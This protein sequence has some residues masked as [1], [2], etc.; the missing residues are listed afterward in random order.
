[1]ACIESQGHGLREGDAIT[2]YYEIDVLARASD[3]AVAH[4]AA[5]G[6]C[7]D[8]LLGRFCRN[9]SEER[10]ARNVIEARGID[11][12]FAPGR[13]RAAKVGGSA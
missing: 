2:F 13:H 4:V 8:A 5:N 7:R 9:G 6:E 11:G 3:Q 10:L 12:V 1:M